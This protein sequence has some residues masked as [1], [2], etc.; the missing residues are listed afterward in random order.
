MAIY[1]NFVNFVGLTMRKQK[2]GLS[3]ENHQVSGPQKYST[4]MA[5][6][7]M[8]SQPKQPMCANWPHWR[9]SFNSA[10]RWKSPQ[11]ATL[12]QI[13]SWPL[14]PSTS[15]PLPFLMLILML[16]LIDKV[17]WQLMKKKKVLSSPKCFFFQVQDEDLSSV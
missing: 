14:V 13:R 4:L 5:K 8:K 6:P 12:N 9:T 17:C 1:C 11:E 16:G 15:L 7:N 3:G 10:F 2:I